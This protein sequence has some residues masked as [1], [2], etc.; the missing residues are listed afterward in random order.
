MTNSARL[1][2]V[3]LAVCL[4]G[5]A[6][7]ADAQAYAATSEPFKGKVDAYVTRAGDSDAKRHPGS[8]N[9]AFTSLGGGRSKLDVVANIDRPRDAGFSM[10]G[11]SS[12]GGWR[13]STGGLSLSIDPQGRISGGGMQQGH[14]IRFGGTATATRM[15]LDVTLEL[16]QANAQGL[17]AGSTI[18]FDYSLARRGAGALAGAPGPRAKKKGDEK[19]CNK[20]VWQVRNVASPGGGMTMTQVPVCVD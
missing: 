7:D 1:L 17:P 5:C 12:N 13:G 4:A 18:R 20:T 19:T 14:R 10:V 2:S 15:D 8:G 16:L 9:A 3:A 11:A 6:G